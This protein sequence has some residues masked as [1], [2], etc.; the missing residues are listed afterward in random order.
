MARVA[1]RLPRLASLQR[2]APPPLADRLLRRENA[3]PATLC[4]PETDN[5]R[6]EGP[7][8]AHSLCCGEGATHATPRDFETDRDLGEGSPL[9]TLCG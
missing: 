2:I 7:P 4:G 5:L 8:L 3:T 9:R 6:G 1:P